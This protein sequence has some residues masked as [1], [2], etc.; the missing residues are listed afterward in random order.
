MLSKSALYAVFSCWCVNESYRL[1]RNSECLWQS[2]DT[3]M[4]ALEN[5]CYL[6]LF[7]LSSSLCFCE[8]SRCSFIFIWERI[9]EHASEAG[10]CELL[11]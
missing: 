8:S 3:C 11:S 2:A 7:I 4:G 1:H 9:D 6:Q 10:Y 5:S